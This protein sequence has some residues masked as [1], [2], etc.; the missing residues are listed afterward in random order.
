MQGH[1][2]FYILEVPESFSST[3]PYLSYDTHRPL[4]QPQQLVL[5]I[6]SFSCFVMLPLVRALSTC[7]APPT[8][9]KKITP[10]RK[11]EFKVSQ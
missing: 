8:Q 6:F 5:K 3:L 10:V 1:L 9:A 2:H 11:L 7:Y 4:A